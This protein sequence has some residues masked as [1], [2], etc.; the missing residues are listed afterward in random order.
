MLPSGGGTISFQPASNFDFD[1]NRDLDFIPY[2]QYAGSITQFDCDDPDLNNFI[3]RQ[4]EVGFYEKENLGRTTLVLCKK[5][6]TPRKIIAYYTIS[7][8]KIS[9][10]ERHYL[11]KKCILKQFPTIKIGRLAVI[12]EFQDKGIGHYCLDR[13]LLDIEPLTKIIGIRFIDVDAYNKDRTIKFYEDYGFVVSPLQKGDGRT[14]PM[15]LDL[16][17]TVSP[18]SIRP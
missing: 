11:R 4:D 5:E 18:T 13:I 17:E 16:K 7:S 3:L 6:G 14:V 15:Y 9:I 8:S 1:P 2:G 10:E 12:K